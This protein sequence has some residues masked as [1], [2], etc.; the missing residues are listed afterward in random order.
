[1]KKTS[2]S[3]A[4]QIADN[5]SDLPSGGRDVCA[6]EA[7]VE[8]VRTRVG[9]ADVA[10]TIVREGTLHVLPGRSLGI[11]YCGEMEDREGT[12][13]RLFWLDVHDFQRGVLLPVHPPHVEAVS[14]DPFGGRISDLR[15][16]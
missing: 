4:L 16:R 8:E 5:S 3:E 13:G 6:D 15:G 11:R 1:M 14:K 2:S 7:D 9:G 10:G 12:R